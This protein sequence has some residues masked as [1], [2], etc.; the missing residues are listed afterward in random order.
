MRSGYGDWEQGQGQHQAG[1]GVY[2]GASHLNPHA[3]P[4]SIDHHLDH[5]LVANMDQHGVPGAESMHIM[6]FQGRCARQ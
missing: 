2:E 6:D 1:A 4:Y 5:H 3:N